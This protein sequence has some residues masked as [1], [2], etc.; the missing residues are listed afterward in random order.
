MDYKVI[1]RII[2][3]QK[4]DKLNEMDKFLER[5]K[6][7]KLAKEEIDNL[8]RSIESKEIASVIKKLQRKTQPRWLHHWILPNAKKR[9][10]G[11]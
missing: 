7:S 8:S 2:V 10:K 4:F 3:G 6:L 11:N 5:Q 1:L 9:K